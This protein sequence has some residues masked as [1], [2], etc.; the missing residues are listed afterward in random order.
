MQL[1]KGAQDTTQQW[2][3]DWRIAC[4]KFQ[5]LEEERID[6]LKTYLWTYANLISTVCV[7]DDEVS[8]CWCVLSIDLGSKFIIILL[9]SLYSH[10]RELE[11][12]WNIVM[13]KR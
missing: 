6:S 12:H 1:V 10:V 9:F 4:D 3:Y 2:N 13:L 8:Q 5:D 7:A 11:L